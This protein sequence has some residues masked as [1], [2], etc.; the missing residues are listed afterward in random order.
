VA[1]PKSRCAHSLL[2]RIFKC[3]APANLSREQMR[4]HHSASSTHTFLSRTKAHGQS[5]TESQEEIDICTFPNEHNRGGEHAHTRPQTH[6]NN[7]KSETLG[8]C[9]HPLMCEYAADL[10]KAKTAQI[11]R[12]NSFSFTRRVVFLSHCSQSK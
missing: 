1:N 10:L 8:E 12:G 5:L 9:A 7:P 6:I 4:A 11:G 3:I 2:Y